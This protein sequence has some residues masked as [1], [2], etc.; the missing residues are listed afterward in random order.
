MPVSADPTDVWDVL[1]DE[2]LAEVS[3]S[4]HYRAAE[5]LLYD[6]PGYEQMIAGLQTEL[7]GLMPGRS[8]SIVAVA[9]IPGASPHDTPEPEKWATIRIEGAQAREIQSQ[10]VYL[11]KCRACVAAARAC[12]SRAELRYADLR[13]GTPAREH[14]QPWRVRRMLNMPERTYYRLRLR[15]IGRVLDAG[16]QMLIFPAIP[17]NSGSKAAVAERDGV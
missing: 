9:S 14:E 1:S 16:R 11:R 7:D 5:K 13:Y 12:M 8:R 17:A 6:W 3:Q 2:Q 15:V 10:M 4:E